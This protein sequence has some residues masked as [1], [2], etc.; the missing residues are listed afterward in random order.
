MNLRQIPGTSYEVGKNFS[1]LEMPA[2]SPF[3]VPWWYRTEFALPAEAAGRTLWL[4]LD[5]VNF[6]FDVWLNGTRIAEAAKTAGAFRVHEID[7]T[8]VGEGGPQRARRARLRPEADRP[9][10]HLRRLEP[11]PPDKVMGLYRPVTLVATGP[12]T[13]RHP[14]V[15]TRLNPPSNDRAE[16]TVKV[17]AP[18][19]SDAP[20]SGTLQ[21]PGRGG[22]LPEG[23]RPRG[24]RVARAR[25]LAGRVPAASARAAEAVVA[26]P[27]RR[28]RPSRRRAR[29]RPRG[30]PSPTPSARSSASAS[31]PRS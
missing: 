10:D 29:V 2:D 26:R 7:V 9:R 22:R 8:S 25:P 24:R 5:G 12:V 19:A 30:R 28:A 15:V 11:M 23:G 21:G 16:L 3:A 14:Q 6:R 20:V 13:L 27:V 17:F 31:S 18:N 1:N 4:R